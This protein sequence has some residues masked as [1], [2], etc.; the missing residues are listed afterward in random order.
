[1][2]GKHC[3]YATR[4]AKLLLP[5]TAGGQPH[6]A[7]T[8]VRA[9][10]QRLPSLDDLQAAINVSLLQ[11]CLNHQRALIMLHGLV[12][13]LQL[14]DVVCADNNT[15]ESRR[16][17][18]VVHGCS[19]LYMYCYLDT[20]STLLCCMHHI[21]AEASTQDS[22]VLLKVLQG[23]TSHVDQQ[24]PGHVPVTTDCSTSMR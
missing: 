10:T 14:H 16:L 6:T 22:I 9:Y 23:V 18:K 8:C 2:C 21:E 3:C 17:P 4:I 5:V 11:C 24:Q 13:C 15:A 20:A 1:M 7:A 12:R 19:V